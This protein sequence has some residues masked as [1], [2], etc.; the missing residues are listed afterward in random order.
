M[1]TCPEATELKTDPKIKKMIPYKTPFC[2][3]ILKAAQSDLK[4]NRYSFP[5]INAFS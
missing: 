5:I 1:V 4:N 2:L 3:R